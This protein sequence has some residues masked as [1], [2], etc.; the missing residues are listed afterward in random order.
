MFEK[1]MLERFNQKAASSDSKSTEILNSLDIKEG[2]AIA[3]IGSGGGYFSIEFAKRVGK[4]GVVYAVDVNPKNLSYVKEK[5]S[6]AGVTNVQTTLTEEDKLNLPLN[7]VDIIFLRNVFHHIPNPTQYFKALK[8]VLKN[9]GIIAI[10]DYKK[11]KGGGIFSFV[12]LFKHYVPQEEIQK[13]LKDA[14]YK[15][16]KSYDFLPQQ[17]FKVFK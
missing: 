10:I 16:Q 2:C 5:A 7:S 17:S 8:P 15:V 9:G 11:P 14:G 13:A 6:A 3:D 1:A 4:S 12:G